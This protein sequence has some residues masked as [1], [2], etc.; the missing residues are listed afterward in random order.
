MTYV[1]Y[2]SIFSSV[3]G[4]DHGDVSYVRQQLFFCLMT[5]SMAMYAGTYHSL[6]LVKIYEVCRYIEVFVDT[7]PCVDGDDMATAITM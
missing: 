4:N 2:V 7:L 6:V 5:T 1:S 3:D